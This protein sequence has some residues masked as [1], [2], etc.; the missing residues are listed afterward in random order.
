MVRRSRMMGV[1]SMLLAASSLFL[2][3]CGGGAGTAGEGRTSFTEEEL[4]SGH[5]S[6]QIEENLV[7]DADIT[8]RET[9]E[10]EYAV[11]Y[12]ESV[13]EPDSG[14]EG[15][16]RKDPTVFGH[17]HGEWQEMLQQLEPGRLTGDRF[18]MG[19]SYMVREKFKGRNGQA[20][21]FFGSWSGEAGKY[22]LSTPFN[23]LWIMMERKGTV[24]SSIQQQAGYIMALVPDYGE[25]G[26]DFLPDPDGEAERIGRFLEEMS[27]RAVNSGYEYVPASS[28]NVE[29]LEERLDPDIFPDVKMEDEY[30][31]YLFWY[32]VD[33]LPLHH[34]LLR[35][36][37]KDDETADRLSL[38][39]ALPN[40]SSE[41]MAISES[42]QFAAVDGDGLLYLDCSSMWR[43]GD[44]CREKGAVVGPD[45]ALA[46]TREYYEKTLLPEKVTVRDIRLTYAGYFVNEG[47][48]VRPVLTP[49]WEVE[50]CDRPSDDMS[51]GCRFAY[52]AF[53]GECLLERGSLTWIW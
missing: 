3:A 9:W 43:P 44:V 42:T 41:L 10:K 37:L 34:L 35:Y 6:F 28:E 51:S 26:L 18:R 25:S 38:W 2:C 33:G 40:S 53:T 29:K 36:H 27:G 52:D 30:A 45:K 14:D 46:M 49:V 50:V 5:A 32:D 17:T 24:A 1:L 13:C 21:R 23:A 22:G 47:G 15:A 39:S 48:T 4:E 16:F 7:V 12:T 11:Y 8:P 31:Y 19:K 20:Y